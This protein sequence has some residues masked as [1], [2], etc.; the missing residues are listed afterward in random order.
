MPASALTVTPNDTPN[1]DATGDGFRCD[2]FFPDKILNPHA[3]AVGQKVMSGAMSGNIRVRLEVKTE[4]VVAIIV[5]TES[6]P[7][8]T[9][10]TIE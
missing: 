5:R 4:D 1:I 9:L 10:Y 3:L 2:A 8:S 6:G 7:E